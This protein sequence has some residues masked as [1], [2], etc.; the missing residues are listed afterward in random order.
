[1][2]LRIR[3][4]QCWHFMKRTRRR[5]C[6]RAYLALAHD[7]WLRQQNIDGSWRYFP[8][9]GMPGTGSMTCA[10]IASVF[11]ATGRLARGTPK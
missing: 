6:E 9:K 2:I 11:I 7:D 1:M 8:Q 5:A 10:G 3:N 4:S